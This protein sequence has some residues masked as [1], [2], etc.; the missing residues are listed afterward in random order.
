LVTWLK[1]KLEKIND[2]KISDLLSQV[3]MAIILSQL[4]FDRNIE[5]IGKFLFLLEIN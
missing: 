1:D 2:V 5:Q 3:P 4:N